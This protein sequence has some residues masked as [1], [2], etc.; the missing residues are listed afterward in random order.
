MMISVS[1]EIKL[2]LILTFPII[3]WIYVCNPNDNDAQY[4]GRYSERNI[5]T[6]AGLVENVVVDGSN[7][8]LADGCIIRHDGEACDVKAETL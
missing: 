1:P 3:W 8:G 7:E 2:A 4:V 6:S 5:H